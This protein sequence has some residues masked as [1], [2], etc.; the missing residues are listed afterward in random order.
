MGVI[1]KLK[2]EIK[3]YILE[4]KKVKPE[5]SCRKLTLLIENKYKIKLS[6]SSIN[7]VI[8]TANLSM[9]IGRRRKHKRRPSEI[10]GLGA[11]LLKAADSLVGGSQYINEEIMKKVEKK[12][13][14]TSTK[15][16]YLIYSPLFTLPEKLSLTSDCGLFHLINSR[17]TKEEIYSY[18]TYLQEFKELETRVAVIIPEVF[19]EVRCVKFT[20]ANGGIFYLD[21]QLHTVWS[22]PNI[23]YDFS[24]TIYNIKGYINKYFKEEKPF[25]LFFAPGYDVPIK[26]FFDFLATIQENAP[27]KLTLYGHKLEELEV[28]TLEQPRNCSLIFGLWPWQFTEFR[29][30]RL[31]GEF[32]SSYIEWLKKDFYLA[33]IEIELLQKTAN[34][35]VTL[36]G[37]AMKRGLNEKISFVILTTLPAEKLNGETLAAVYFSHWPN[38][39]EAFQDFGRKI[40]F[41]TYMA[42]SQRFFST[43]N[44]N[45]SPETGEGLAGAFN[46]YLKALDAYVRWHFLPVGY[47]EKDFSVMKERFYG[48]KAKLKKEKDHI[49]VI[50]NPPLGY[51][52]LKDL[53]YACRRVN[54]REIVLTPENK[55]LWCSVS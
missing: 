53:E 5:L 39:E 50:F 49:W 40:E 17:F 22:T 4:Q 54:E 33:D 16:E 37:C 25:T 18:L 28:I 47:E 12:Q 52:Y 23:P 21:G 48:L 10:E 51:A 26:E 3:N 43:E 41:F 7:T 55:R 44:L 9:P 8:K 20:L 6:K 45:L 31:L 46:Y 30:G 36:R 11:I 34:K 42:G 19:K 24:T 35:R 32:K 14:V 29:K 38:I 2:S 27:F 13:I 15:I 1:Y